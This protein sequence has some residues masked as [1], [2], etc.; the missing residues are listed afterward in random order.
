VRAA[1]QLLD[2]SVAAPGGMEIHPE[3]D[4]DQ[5]A[6]DPGVHERPVPRH[7]PGELPVAAPGALSLRAVGWPA[8]PQLLSV[9]GDRGRHLHGDPV[10]AALL[11]PLARSP[12]RPEPVPA[13]GRAL[14]RD[15]VPARLLLH[16][17]L[18]LDLRGLLAGGAPLSDRRARYAARAEAIRRLRR[19]RGP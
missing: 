6:R 9:G 12:A 16:L 17:D 4:R 1:A 7:R 15:P 10:P 5:S 18:L 13:G 8:E 19:A 11:L 3:P 14:A 2:R